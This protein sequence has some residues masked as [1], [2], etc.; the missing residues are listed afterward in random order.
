[1]SRHKRPQVVTIGDKLRKLREKAGKTQYE[2]AIAAGI[3]PEVLCRLEGNKNPAA[4]SSLHKLAPVLG[5]T[6]ET[7]IGKS[8]KKE[9]SK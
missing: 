6:V 2:V 3:R 4:L 8:E 1:M 5:F 9:K 7:L